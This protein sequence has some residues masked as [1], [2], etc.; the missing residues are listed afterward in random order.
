MGHIQ[1]HEQDEYEPDFSVNINIQVGKKET[2]LTEKVEEIVDLH[3]GALMFSGNN[4]RMYEGQELMSAGDGYSAF[5]TRI[6]TPPLPTTQ[7]VDITGYAT[8]PLPV[9]MPGTAELSNVPASMFRSTTPEIPRSG[10]SGCFRAT[11]PEIPRSGMSGCSRSTTP[12]I[13]ESG[14]S[15]C[16]RSTTPEIPESGVSG[17]SRSTTP[18]IP[19]SG[20]SGCSRSTTPELLAPAGSVT[21]E[22]PPGDFEGC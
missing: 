3:G 5:R 1:A 22:L 14:V 4:F 20:V 7:A 10:V 18:E 15:G 9:L 21:P 19:E 11:T 13:P 8:P 6:I 12:E 2:V 17:C 16:S